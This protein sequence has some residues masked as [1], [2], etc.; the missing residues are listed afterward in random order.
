MKSAMPR[1]VMPSI[2]FALTVE[3]DHM[4]APRWLNIQLL[5]L[6][7]TESYNEVVHFKQIVVLTGY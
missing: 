6:R 2:L 4:F 5:S 3:S 7:F 1:S